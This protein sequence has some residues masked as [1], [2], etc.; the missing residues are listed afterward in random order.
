MQ[1][2]GSRNLQQATLRDE[3][4]TPVKRSDSDYT[5]EILSTVWNRKDARTIRQPANH[6]VKRGV[7]GDNT[8]RHIHCNFMC[9]TISCG[10]CETEPYGTWGAYTKIVATNQVRATILNDTYRFKQISDPPSRDTRTTLLKLR[11]DL[12]AEHAAHRLWNM[13]NISPYRPINFIEYR[14]TTNSGS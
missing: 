10:A 5:T 14:V 13:R 12:C 1:L 3:I 11:M 8:K 9:G 2:T 4:H 7:L 6:A